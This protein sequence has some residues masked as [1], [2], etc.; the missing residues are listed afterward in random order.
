M[1]TRCGIYRDTRGIRAACVAGS[2]RTVRTAADQP[3]T[4]ICLKQLINGVIKPDRGCN[5]MAGREPWAAVGGCDTT[6]GASVALQ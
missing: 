6:R 3:E 1:P 2:W 5:L 4:V